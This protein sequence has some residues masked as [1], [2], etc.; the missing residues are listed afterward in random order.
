MSHFMTFV[1][2]A[3][4]CMPSSVKANGS[5]TALNRAEHLTT[6]DAV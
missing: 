4:F 3:Y 1:Y 5:C 6:D 2:F